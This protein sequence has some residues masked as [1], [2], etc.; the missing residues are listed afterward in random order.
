MGREHRCCRYMC[1]REESGG[2]VRSCEDR[3]AV[4]RE[5]REGNCGGNC[6]K[7]A[8]CD[9]PGIRIYGEV[10]QVKTVDWPLWTFIPLW[11]IV[12]VCPCPAILYCA[13]IGDMRLI[14]ASRNRARA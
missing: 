6:K 7:T 4:F 10:Q 5:G 8:T 2:R 3:T 1:C 9:G 11:V 13:T 12:F 14:E